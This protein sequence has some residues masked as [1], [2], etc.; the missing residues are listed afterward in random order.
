MAKER[1]YLDEFEMNLLEKYGIK[2]LKKKY[3]VNDLLD[4]LPKRW[5]EGNKENHDENWKTIQFWWDDGMREWHCTTPYW[6][7]EGACVKATWNDVRGDTLVECLL[8]A[9]LTLA[10]RDRRFLSKTY[11][12]ED[13]RYKPENK[14]E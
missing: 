4:I 10:K 6:F 3:D 14:D 11:V 9:V 12:V 13:W 1:K 2:R 8:A 7:F 5:K